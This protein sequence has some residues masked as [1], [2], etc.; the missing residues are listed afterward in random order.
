MF[1]CSEWPLRVL[2]F[3]FILWG[4]E[5]RKMF[6]CWK[7]TC[8]H[9]FRYFLP[10]WEPFNNDFVIWRALVNVWHLDFCLGGTEGNPSWHLPWSFFSRIGALCY[11]CVNKYAHY[12]ACLYIVLEIHVKSCYVFIFVCV[13]ECHQFGRKSISNERPN[14]LCCCFHRHSQT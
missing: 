14:R 7:Y 6:I 8:Y 10:Y 9:S 13:W 4:Q 11:K 2:L 5:S 3:I 1:E 12:P